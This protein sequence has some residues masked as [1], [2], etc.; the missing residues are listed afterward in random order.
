MI[1][2]STSCVASF[3]SIFSSR[4]P[5]M[6]SS[7]NRYIRDTR[8]GTPYLGEARDEG[9]ER[10][11][12]FLPHSVE[13]NLHTMLLVRTAKFAANLAQSSSQDWIV[14]GVRFMSQVRAGPDK[15]T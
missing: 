13:V 8:N 6:E 11:P 1:M 5:L 7:D 14:P 10:L 12:G 4:T 9:P 15:A 3:S 2:L